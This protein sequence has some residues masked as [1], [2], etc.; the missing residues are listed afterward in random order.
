VRK[1]ALKGG[2]LQRNLDTQAIKEPYSLVTNEI[3]V[4]AM[5]TSEHK[6]ERPPCDGLLITL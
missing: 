6:S 5:W 3:A 4:D 1:T 2:P